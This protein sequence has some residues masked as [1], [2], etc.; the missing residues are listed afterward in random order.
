MVFAIYLQVIC[1]ISTSWSREELF[2]SVDAWN[3]PSDMLYKTF[4]SSLIKFSPQCAYG[5]HDLHSL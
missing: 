2:L 3:F 5:E 1:C 4:E